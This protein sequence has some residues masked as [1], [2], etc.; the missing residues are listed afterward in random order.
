MKPAP[1][2]YDPNVNL[3]LPAGVSHLDGKTALKLARARNAA[4]GYGLHRSNFDR[5]M[6]QQRIISA[7]FRKISDQRNI[8]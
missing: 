1:G 8:K 7:I 3:R 2:I 5:E 4:G 6:N